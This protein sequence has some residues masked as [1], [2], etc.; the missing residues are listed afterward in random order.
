MS[1]LEEQLV[2][3]SFAWPRRE[4]NQAGTGGTL[5]S[6]PRQALQAQRLFH[7]CSNCVPSSPCQGKQR[8]FSSSAS[9]NMNTGKADDSPRSQGTW[10]PVGPGPQEQVRS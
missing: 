7:C 2:S 9:P 8:S 6:F 1:L 3:R 4:V 10:G 5:P